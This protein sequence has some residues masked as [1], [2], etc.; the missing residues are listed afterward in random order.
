MADDQKINIKFKVESDIKKPAYFDL[1]GGF[2]IHTACSIDQGSDPLDIGDTAIHDL[3]IAVIIPDGFYGVIR[4]LKM[5]KCALSFEQHI[6]PNTEDWITL[7]IYLKRKIYISKDWQFAILHI[8][9]IPD[10]K[11]W[12]SY[13]IIQVVDEKEIEKQ[14][15]EKEKKEKQEKQEKE[16]KEKQEKEKLEKEKKEKEKKEKMV[17]QEKEKLE[18]KELEKNTKKLDEYFYELITSDRKNQ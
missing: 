7:H 18:K 1:L 17:K 6:R 2:I 13:E 5:Y 15:K 4:P 14:K 12:S 3:G 16:K 11:F 10:R 9:K 8:Y